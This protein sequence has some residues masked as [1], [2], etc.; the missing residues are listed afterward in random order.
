MA[1]GYC[2]RAYAYSEMKL[3]HQAIQDYDISLR[4]DPNFSS[5]YILRGTSFFRKIFEFSLNFL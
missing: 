1:M 3:Y 5:A 4:L 2:N